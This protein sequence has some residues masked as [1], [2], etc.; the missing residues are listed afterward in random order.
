LSC[1]QKNEGR[2]CP[3]SWWSFASSMTVLV[4]S[5]LLLIDYVK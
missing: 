4:A 3:A 5:S 2:V 1:C